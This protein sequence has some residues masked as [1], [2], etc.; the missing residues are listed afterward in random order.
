MVLKLSS[1]TWKPCCIK[2]CC[3]TVKVKTNSLYLRPKQSS[4]K[5]WILQIKFDFRKK[6]NLTS[7]L[8]KLCWWNYCTVTEHHYARASIENQVFRVFSETQCMLLIACNVRCTVC[9]GCSAVCCNWVKHRDWGQVTAG[10][11]SHVSMGCRGGGKPGALRLYQATSDA[12]VR[13]WWWHCK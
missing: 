1:I 13:T 5:I 2:Y 4:N 8:M 10:Q 12:H 9:V 6:T 11:G 3:H 7:L